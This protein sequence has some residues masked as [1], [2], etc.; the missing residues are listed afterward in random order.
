M[1]RE[2]ARE[3]R[4]PKKLLFAVLAMMMRKIIIYNPLREAELSVAS[5]TA[6][7]NVLP[8]GRAADEKV[9]EEGR[10]IFSNSVVCENPSR[11]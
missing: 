3:A 6:K 8:K 2:H 4:S 7:E 11:I 10:K 1:V 9:K 5:G